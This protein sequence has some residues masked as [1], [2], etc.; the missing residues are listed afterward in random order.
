MSDDLLNRKRVFNITSDIYKVLTLGD[1]CRCS[2]TFIN[3]P[4]VLWHWPKE[5]M[6]QTR[7]RRDIE[8]ILV[9]GINVRNQKRFIQVFKSKVFIIRT[10]KLYIFLYINKCCLLVLRALSLA[11]NTGT[12]IYRLHSYSDT[13]KFTKYDISFEMLHEIMLFYYYIH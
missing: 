10:V 13:I 12:Y 11:K 9:R 5:Q 7:K 2:P 8:E 6:N 3:T 4:V 1:W